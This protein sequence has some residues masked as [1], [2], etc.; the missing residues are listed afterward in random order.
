M[1]S[2]KTDSRIELRG[3]LDSLNAEIICVQARHS[4]DE[5]FVADLEELREIVRE[6]QRCEASGTAF[7][8]KFTLW[9]LD[10]DELHVK[11]HSPSGESGKHIMMHHSMGVKAAEINRLRV[12]VRE[13]ELCAWGVF[14]DDDLR[15][16]HVLNRLSSALYVLIY[17]YLPRD[18]DKFIAFGKV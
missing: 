6:L 7:T 14:P 15:V 9:G 13:C 18:Y 12:I 4:D 10:E 5:S 1:S 8:G 11:S 3:R 2:Y 16:N 17:E